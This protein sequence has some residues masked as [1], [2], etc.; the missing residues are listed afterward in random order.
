MHKISLIAAM[1]ENNVIG[2][3]NKLVWNLPV[4]WENFRNVTKN[5]SFIMGRVSFESEHKLL[6]EKRNIILTKRKDYT[7]DENIETA[8]SIE[9]AL[10]L[11]KEEE[12]I[13]ILGGQN[14]FEQ[15]IE[16]ADYLYLTIVHHSFKGDAFF[17]KINFD[18]WELTK[19]VKH[20]KD[21]KHAYSLSLNE[22]KKIRK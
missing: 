7:S 20:E 18:S 1:S 13:F 11:L 3:D 15:T 17:P 9:E 2:I 12:E 6:S 14:I 5:S 19:S 4:D 21:D 10:K 22:Y 16:I 8:N